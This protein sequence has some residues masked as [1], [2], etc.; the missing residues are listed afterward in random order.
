MKPQNYNI[1]S[2]LLELIEVLE[3]KA[4]SCDLMMGFQCDIH[5][6]VRRKVLEIRKRHE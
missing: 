2:E 6:F 4:C 1:T 3:K 5:Q